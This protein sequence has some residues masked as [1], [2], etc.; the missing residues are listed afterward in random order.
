MEENYVT[1]ILRITNMTADGR[2]QD[3]RNVR[4]GKQGSESS[5]RYGKSA[6]HAWNAGKNC[7]QVGPSQLD[8]FH[9]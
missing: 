6:Y 3:N 8:V 1:V 5:A 4:A 7:N 2:R 9:E